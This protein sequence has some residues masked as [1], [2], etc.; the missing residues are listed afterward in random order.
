MADATLTKLEIELRAERAK[1]SIRCTDPACEDGRQY[2]RHGIDDDRREPCHVCD[3][4]GKTD[5]VACAECDARLDADD[6]ACSCGCVDRFLCRACAAEPD[7]HLTTCPAICA[8]CGKPADVIG[9]GE[10]LCFADWH[11]AHGRCAHGEPEAEA[12]CR[13]CAEAA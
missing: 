4:E 10:P 13:G 12:A 9:E 8:A 11:A 3:G 7:L 6:V 2:Y 5:S 1:G